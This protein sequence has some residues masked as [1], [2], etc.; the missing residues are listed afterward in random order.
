MRVGTLHTHN[1]AE[2]CAQASVGRNL[3]DLAPCRESSWFPSK[4]KRLFADRDVM[5]PTG[6]PWPC[7]PVR[8]RVNQRRERGLT[9]VFAAECCCK[10]NPQRLFS[11]SPDCG[12]DIIKLNRLFELQDVS[13]F[14][15]C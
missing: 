9:K 8:Q 15:Q 5:T 10:K 4:H 7:S 12:V 1:P 3:Q 6:Q 11:Y 14:T 2:T 13:M